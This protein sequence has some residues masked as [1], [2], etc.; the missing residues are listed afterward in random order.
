[1]KSTNK[2]ITCNFCSSRQGAALLGLLDIELLA[3]C[4]CST[5]DAPQSRK[6]VNAQHYICRL[7]HKQQLK[8]HQTSKIVYIIDYFLLGPSRKAD[9][10]ASDN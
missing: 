1:M 2:K 6:H 10:E 9:K 8:I 7:Q 5:I 4:K 3:K